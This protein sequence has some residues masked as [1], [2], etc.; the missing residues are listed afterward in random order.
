MLTLDQALEIADR[1]QRNGLREAVGFGHAL[2]EPVGFLRRSAARGIAFEAVALDSARTCARVDP[3]GDL[4][5][6]AHD[7]AR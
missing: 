7:D 6:G 4:H 1:R 2:G 5:F 3:R